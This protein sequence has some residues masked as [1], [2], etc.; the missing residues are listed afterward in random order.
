MARRGSLGGITGSSSGMGV[1]PEAAAWSSARKS[2]I[3]VALGMSDA[4]NGCLAA[5]LLIILVVEGRV[6]RIAP[7]LL[8]RCVA[9]GLVLR[10]SMMVQLVVVVWLGGWL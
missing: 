7:T 5:V 2:S 8:L 1:R 3:S 4:S 10:R 6:G 9:A